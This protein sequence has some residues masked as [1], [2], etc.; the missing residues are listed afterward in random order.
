MKETESKKLAT[1]DTRFALMLGDAVVA[2]W[3]QLPRDSQQLIF[4]AA[5]A[6]DGTLREPLAL[7]LHDENPRTAE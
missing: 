4:E 6:S 2:V 7:F 5:A 3:A 1:D